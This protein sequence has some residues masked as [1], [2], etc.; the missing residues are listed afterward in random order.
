M[1]LLFVIHNIRPGGAE[2]VLVMLANYLATQGFQVS[3]LIFS[4]DEPFYDINPSIDL[5]RI[6]NNLENKSL[7][8]KVKFLF[9]NILCNS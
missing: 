7:F 8:G 5:I 1:K 9:K 4:E 6:K 2:R 3:I